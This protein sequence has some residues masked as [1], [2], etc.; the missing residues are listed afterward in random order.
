MTRPNITPGPWLQNAKVPRIIHSSAHDPI[1][2]VN[3]MDEIPRPQETANSKAIAA[4]P[5]LLKALE[6]I[7]H[8]C[9][10][11]YNSERARNVLQDAGYTF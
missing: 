6:E 2:E 1:C 3:G 5:A 9:R 10:S 4:L 11:S 8:D 7:A